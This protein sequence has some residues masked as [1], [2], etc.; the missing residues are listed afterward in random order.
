M[1]EM[2]ME[3]EGMELSEEAKAKLLKVMAELKTICGDEGCSMKDAMAFMKD[4][5][6][7]EPMMEE[8]SE[9]SE[10]A[11]SEKAPKKALIIAMLKKKSGMGE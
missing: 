11:D 7:K 3:K 8:E 9:D 10:M 6:G 2:M 5:S 1:E 4:D